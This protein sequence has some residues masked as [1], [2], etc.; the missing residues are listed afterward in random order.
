M[1]PGDFDSGNIGVH[2]SL[3][4]NVTGGC[5]DSGDNVGSRHKI[6]KRLHWQGFCALKKKE[7]NAWF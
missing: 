4:L 3:G 1:V 7:K 5:G 2:S 6:K